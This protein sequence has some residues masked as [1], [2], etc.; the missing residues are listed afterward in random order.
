MHYIIYNNKSNN[1]NN[2]EYINQIKTKLEGMVRLISIFDV[3]S[4]KDLF[5]KLNSEDDLTLIGGDGTMNYFVNSI[6]DVNF[7]CDVY[8]AAGGT[9]N[10]F[11][12]DV[13]DQLDELG[14]VKIND[15]VINLHTVYVNGMKK[16]IINGIGYGIDGYA[17]EAADNFIKKH[18]NKKVNYTSITVKGLLFHYKRP[19][20]EVIVDGDTKKF[21][22]VYLASTMKGRYYGGGMLVAPEQDRKKEDKELTI[23]VWNGSSKLKTLMNFPKIFKGEHV[24]LKNVTIKKGHSVEIRFDKPTSLQIDGET[25]LNVY[26]YKVEA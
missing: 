1:S 25:V 15:Y 14:R 7:P 13:E 2:E 4:Y 10:D 12:K 26:S 21:K 6:D 17:C 8:F 20:A 23:L 3:K 11:I 19:N 5:E 16:N 9:G 22:K 18:P 24:T